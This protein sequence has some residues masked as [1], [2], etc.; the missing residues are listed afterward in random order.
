M[1]RG[2][3]GKYPYSVNLVEEE[4][5]GQTGSRPTR[6]AMHAGGATWK[7]PLVR[8]AH[9]HIA[10]SAESVPDQWDA[11]FVMLLDETEIRSRW[12]SNLCSWR[13]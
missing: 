2:K 1:W 6:R 12:R 5:P 7:V 11:G 10:E 13:S 4:D 8:Q 9:T 3:L